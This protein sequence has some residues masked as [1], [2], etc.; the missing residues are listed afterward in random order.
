MLPACERF[1]QPE[2]LCPVEAVGKGKPERTFILPRPPAIREGKGYSFSQA[3]GSQA[4]ARLSLRLHPRAEQLPSFVVA[5]FVR[6]RGAE[7]VPANAAQLNEVI[8]KFG[9]RELV[10]EFSR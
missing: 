5:L 9:A 4:P 6:Y 8:Q 7:A 10:A 3:V 1:R 2:G